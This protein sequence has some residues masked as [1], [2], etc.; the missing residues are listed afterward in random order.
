MKERTRVIMKY[1]EKEDIQKS[2]E[3]EVIEKREKE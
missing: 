1:R 2:E 3:I